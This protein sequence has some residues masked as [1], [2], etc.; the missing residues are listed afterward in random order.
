M[1]LIFLSRNLEIGKMFNKDYIGVIEEN[2]EN[3]ISFNVNI[4]VQLT[5]VTSKD[6]KE[7]NRNIH[8]RFMVSCR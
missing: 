8:L 7:V 1:T 5:E 6:A 2:K 3:H 4:K